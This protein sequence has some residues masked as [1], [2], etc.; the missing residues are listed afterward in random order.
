M[1]A[2]TVA[3][4]GGQQPRCHGSQA[5]TNHDL[6]HRSRGPKP[7]VT[8]LMAR[9]HEERRRTTRRKGQT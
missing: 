9:G 7:T 8:T 1:S 6:R 2:D 3:G 4:G 5:R